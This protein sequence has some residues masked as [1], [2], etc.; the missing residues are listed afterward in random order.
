MFAKNNM[1]FKNIIIT[2]DDLGLSEGINSGISKGIENGSINSVSLVAGG[3]A[4]AG[5]VKVVKNTGV[6]V[7]VHL[8]FIEEK[9]LLETAKLPFITGRDGRFFPTLPSLVLALY[10]NKGTIKNIE[11]EAK[12]QIERIL[13]AGMKPSFLNSHQHIHMLPV[14][15]RK[16][17]S[18]A[19]KY[20]IKAIRLSNEHI[21]KRRLLSKKSLSRLPGIILLKYLSAFN[22][23]NIGNKR[24]K[25]NDYTMG[26]LASGSLDLKIAADIT[27]CKHNKITELICHPGDQDNSLNNYKHWGYHWQEE[28]TVLLSP[29]FKEYIKNKDIKI[30]SFREL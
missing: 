1:A 16:F 11:L 19:D 20:N 29:V 5:A 6:D 23:A 17:I 30:T 24:L 28:L 4:F 21:I 26:V 25:Y 15:F 22:R 18:L 7:G 3:N 8:T 10:S 9:P 13:D 27:R 2:A 14:L 12:A